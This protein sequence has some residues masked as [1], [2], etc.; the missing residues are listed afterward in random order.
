MNDDIVVLFYK[1]S[2][3]I[4]TRINN[5][6]R[7]YSL[8]FQQF[9]ILNFVAQQQGEVIGKDICQYLGISHPTAV[10]LVTRMVG[11]DFL[12]VKVS[13]S[14]RRQTTLYLSEK[15]KLILSQTES[16]V[17]NIQDEI[18]NVLGENHQEILVQMEGLKNLLNI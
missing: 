16:I 18:M 6:L 2:S 15:G 7:P 5:E 4:V 17:Q 13:Q 10:G 9:S 3:A 14:D 11:N 1:L 8:T 12:I